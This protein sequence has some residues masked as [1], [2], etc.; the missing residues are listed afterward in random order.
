MEFI[1][2]WHRFTY[3]YV[4]TMV[5][6]NNMLTTYFKHVSK[7]FPVDGHLTILITDY[8]YEKLND[9]TIIVAIEE[10]H[11]TYVTRNKG[12]IREMLF[13]HGPIECWDVRN[14][15]ILENAFCRMIDFN[16]DIS[17]WDVSNVLSLKKAFFDTKNFSGNVT[18]WDVRNVTNMDYIFR[19]SENFGADLSNWNVKN[20][21]SM[22]GA[23]CGS[24]DFNCDISR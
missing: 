13:R 15:T 17:G 16:Y 3:L 21:Q 6:R 24:K 19:C 10:Y 9:R 4:L 1:I 18:H 7:A 22:E 2:I 11:Y 23:F 5:N 12:K 14:I 8:A 20:V